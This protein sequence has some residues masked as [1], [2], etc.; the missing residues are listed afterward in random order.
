MKHLSFSCVAVFPFPPIP[1]SSYCLHISTFKCDRM[2]WFKVQMKLCKDVSKA[3]I[4]KKTSNVK[5]KKR[6]RSNGH[7]LCTIVYTRVLGLKGN[8]TSHISSLCV[9]VIKRDSGTV[10]VNTSV[11]LSLTRVQLTAIFRRDR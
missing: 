8:S 10:L 5:Q 3:K 2:I 4:N 6:P 1:Y 7:L 9:S 11:E